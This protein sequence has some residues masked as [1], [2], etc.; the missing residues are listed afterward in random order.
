MGLLQV[1]RMPCGGDLTDKTEVCGF[2]VAL[3]TDSIGYILSVTAF[4][5]DLSS[6][7]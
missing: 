5:R 6:A 2:N 7:L 3:N 4:C 1:S